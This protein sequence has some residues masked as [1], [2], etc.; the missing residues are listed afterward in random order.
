[1]GLS[2]RKIKQR[3]GNDPRNLSWADDAA[4]FGSSYL[5]KF[6]WDSSKGLGVSGEGRTSHIKV[7]QKLD[8]MGIGAAHQQDPNGLAWKQNKDFENLLRRLNEANG[9]V[10]EQT[11]IVVDGFVKPKGDLSEEADE[12]KKEKEK[13][14][15]DVDDADRKKKKN[16]K[17]AHEPTPE[18]SAKPTET[19]SISPEPTAIIEQRASRVI[20]RH[21]SHRARHIAAKTIGSKT[22]IAISEILGIAPTPSLSSSVAPSGT[23]TPREGKLTSIYDDN[24]DTPEVDKIT[25]STKSLQD[26]FKEKMSK[27]QGPASSVPVP[28]LQSEVLETDYDDVP[29][30][31]LGLRPKLVLNE[32]DAPRLGLSKFS[33]LISSSFMAATSLCSTF[34]SAEA[35]GSIAKADKPTSAEKDS[36]EE[37]QRRRRKKEKKGL[38]ASKKEREEKEEGRW[39]KADSD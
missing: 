38:K 29:R 31:G 22:A 27:L 2:G 7:A 4:R 12:G 17:N 18:P 21:R 9:I 28:T 3:I 14:Y 26:Y 13:E 20:P 30:S 23:Q 34:E 32:D 11:G 24:E 15:E 19:V 6:G 25:T 5:T 10:E 33:A 36:G 16:K 8:M 37:R 1:M 39:R 35:E